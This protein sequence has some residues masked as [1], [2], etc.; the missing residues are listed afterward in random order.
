MARRLSIGLHG[1]VVDG[2]AAVAVLARLIASTPALVIA[3]VIAMAAI[4]GAFVVRQ[5]LPWMPTRDATSDEAMSNPAADRVGAHEPDPGRSDHANDDGYL[6]GLARAL[7][8]NSVEQM[9]R[10]GR[11]HPA[12]DLVRR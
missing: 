7:G 11:P 3:L 8:Y 4:G 12:D 9:A 10:A 6:D 5:G 1:S 2:G